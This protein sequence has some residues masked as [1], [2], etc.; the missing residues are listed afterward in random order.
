MKFKENDMVVCVSTPNSSLKVGAI[1]KVLE[2]VKD[3]TGGFIKLLNDNG[4]TGFYGSHRFKLAPK[5]KAGD[6]VKCIDNADGQL[7]S[8]H[9]TI[10]STY[11]IL[12]PMDDYV[13]LLND[14]GSLG[15]YRSE[16]FELADKEKVK[17]NLTIE[18]DN[19]ADFLYKLENAYNIVSEVAKTEKAYEEAYLKLEAL[20]DD[21]TGS[22][23]LF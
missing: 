4:N 5:F 13:M 23:G 12:D 15:I 20:L 2:V 7:M 17:F 1:Y 3:G 10:G 8:P 19:I 6:I 11:E 14:C 22:S 21:K 18:E 9:L 16:R